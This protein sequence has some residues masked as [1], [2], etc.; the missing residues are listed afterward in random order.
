MSI[1][2]EAKN[3]HKIYRMG[4]Q[5]VHALR[6]VDLSIE[7]GRFYAVIGKSGSGKSTLLHVLSGLDEPTEGKVLLGGKELYALSDD[8]LSKMRRRKI[9]FVFQ[10]YNLLPEFCVEE[11]IRMP[12]YIDGAEGD[13]VYLKQLISKLGIREILSKFPSQ[14]S[15]GEQQRVAVARAMAAK[16]AIVFADEPTGNLDQKNGREVMRLFKMA[17]EMFG[18]TVVLVTHDLE[19]A[20]MADCVIRMQDGVIL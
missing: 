15:G 11:N 12:L 1:I 6:C 19:I 10:A 13:N 8:K 7:G 14:L 2:L 20:K 16:P 4:E 5:K 3:I 18:Q 17:Q 9:G